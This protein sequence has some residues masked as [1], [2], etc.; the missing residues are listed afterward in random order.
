MPAGPPCILGMGV[1]GL[2][3]QHE[4]TQKRDLPMQPQAQLDPMHLPP[5]QLPPIRTSTF[6]PVP[7]GQEATSSRSNLSECD[8]FEPGGGTACSSPTTPPCSPPAYPRSPPSAPRKIS[9]RNL[10]PRYMGEAAKSLLGPLPTKRSLLP[11]LDAA[12]AAH[13]AVPSDALPQWHAPANSAP[14]A[15]R[16]ESNAPTPTVPKRR[17]RSIGDERQDES[18]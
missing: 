7:I 1:P 15:S 14:P 18:P 8:T 12:A 11:A 6:T 16:D 9:P 5:Q 2:D 4:P 3:D 17:R 10:A 13:S